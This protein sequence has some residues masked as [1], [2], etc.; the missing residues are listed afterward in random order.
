MIG[1]NTGFLNQLKFQYSW[2]AKTPCI[3]KSS[4]SELKSLCR[5][6]MKILEL[7]FRQEF[8]RNKGLFEAE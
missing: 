8:K 4:Q 1:P 2:C 3:Q 5:V 6:V 7:L